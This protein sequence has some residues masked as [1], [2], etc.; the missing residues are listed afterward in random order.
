MYWIRTWLI[1]IIFPSRPKQKN[2]AKVL[3]HGSCPHEPLLLY[4][5]LFLYY[6]TLVLSF[7]L[8]NVR[9][10]AQAGK[11]KNKRLEKAGK[12]PCLLLLFYSFM[13]RILCICLLKTSKSLVVSY[14]YF[15]SSVIELK[16]TQR[17]C[18]ISYNITCFNIRLQPNIHRVMDCHSGF[19][20]Q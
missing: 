4:N 15:L 6:K 14:R 3:F 1:N 7:D 12:K 10:E 16:H 17:R 9:T 19:T 13:L 11:A 20:H 8:K 2:R 18:K 5:L